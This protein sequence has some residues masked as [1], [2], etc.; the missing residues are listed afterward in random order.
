MNI[1]LHEN[2]R[3]PHCIRTVTSKATLFWL[4]Q[5]KESLSFPDNAFII[6]K[7]IHLGELVNHECADVRFVSRD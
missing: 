7:L 2:K 5:M 4:I 1:L 3:Y 6:V